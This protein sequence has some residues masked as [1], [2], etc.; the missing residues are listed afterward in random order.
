MPKGS[1]TLW[2]KALNP[3]QAMLLPSHCQENEHNKSLFYWNQFHSFDTN[4][5]SEQILSEIRAKFN[6]V[7]PILGI[8]VGNLQ[9]VSVG[10]N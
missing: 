1:E 2:L 5:T 7:N 3:P 9:E 10:M 8:E 6:V 4:L